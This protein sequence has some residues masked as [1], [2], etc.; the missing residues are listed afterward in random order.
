ML[1]IFPSVNQEGKLVS[2]LEPGQNMEIMQQ[3]VAAVSSFHSANTFNLEKKILLKIA[4][5]ITQRTWLSSWIFLRHTCWSHVHTNPR[6]DFCNARTSLSNVVIYDIK[7]PFGLFLIE[8]KKPDKLFWA[9][10]LKLYVIQKMLDRIPE[11][12]IISGWDWIE[13]DLLY[14]SLFKLHP[15]A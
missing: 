10:P 7:V 14:F 9:L 13:K 1:R 15:F 12:V 3:K 11:D 5:L 2:V 8:E 4:F 6:I